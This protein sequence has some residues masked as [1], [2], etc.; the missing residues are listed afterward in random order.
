MLFSFKIKKWLRIEA[1][2]LL[3][4]WA[5]LSAGSN[6]RR[7]QQQKAENETE[8]ARYVAAAFKHG[9]NSNNSTD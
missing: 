9:I 2:Y 8:H 4:R 1:I 5:F 6:P 3:L 7:T